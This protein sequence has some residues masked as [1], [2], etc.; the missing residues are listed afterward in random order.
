MGRETFYD[1]Q[2]CKAN[3][4]T[5][6]MQIFSVLPVECWCPPHSKIEF[7]FFFFHVWSPVNIKLLSVNYCIFFLSCCKYYFYLPTS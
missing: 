4:L 1:R 5:R 6:E 7:F 3:F 2:I